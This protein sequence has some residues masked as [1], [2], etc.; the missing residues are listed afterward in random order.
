MAASLKTVFQSTEGGLKGIG[1][2]IE[3]L[4]KKQ[5]L[6]TNSIQTFGRMGKNVDGLRV[7]Y[8]QVTTQVNRL[9]AAQTRLNAAQAKYNTLSSAAGKLKGA[10]A[11]LAMA[12]TVLAAPLVMGVSEAKKYQNEQAKVRA[13][14]LGTGVTSDAF[15]FAK[16]MKTYGTSQLDNLTLVRDALSVFGD[17]DDAKMAA[18]ILA[19]MKFGNAAVF[20]SEQGAENE[21]KF[22]DM[23]KVIELRNGT[24]SK[25]AFGAQANMVQK[26]I[27][28]TGGRVGPE[29]WR[30]LIATGGL[31]AKGMRDDAFYFQL[32]HLVQES[33]G[34]R[35]GTGLSAAY[36]SLYQGRTTKRALLNLEK[37]GLIGDKSKTTPDKA[38]QI[39]HINPG[40][41]LGSD[42]FRQSQFEWVKQVL[43]PTLAK[44]G[45]TSKDAITDAIG[46][47]VSNRK[48]GDLLATM[49]LQQRQIEKDER[50]S[51][52]SYGVDQLDK[53][54]RNNAGGKELDAEAK[55]NN[56][57]LQMGKDIMPL[58]IHAL[59]LG[60]SA[61]EK[62]NGFMERNPLLTK[63]MMV[64]LAGVASAALVLSPIL[65]TVGG[66][67]SAYAGYTLLMGK[68]AVAAAQGT[69]VMG[70]LARGIM[71]VGTTL[72]AVSMAML[73]SPI[74]WIVA[75]LGIAAYELYKHWDAVKSWF[76][77][78]WADMK[79]IFGGAVDFIT[80]LMTGNFTKAIDGLKESFGGLGSFVKHVFDG[81]SQG[82]ATVVNDAL[83]A[84]GII[85]QTR[86][87]NEVGK[88][89][90]EK[91]KQTRDATML[92]SAKALLRDGTMALPAVAGMWRSYFNQTASHDAAV[93]AIK[94]NTGAPGE[95][96]ELPPM[97]S[98]RGGRGNSQGSVDA[99]SSQP[100][101]ITNNWNITQQPGEDSEAFA[102]RVA[103]AHAEQMAKMQR[104]QLIDGVNN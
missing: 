65:V 43:I 101:Q 64:G 31:A 104:G 80:G 20:G 17:I 72:R 102:Q 76:S 52:G 15:R 25:E 98:S 9:Q 12:G 71:T 97:A 49:Y 42:L 36:S 99:D 28:A 35:V 16:Q 59:E 79:N 103:Q 40:A 29:E 70:I 1:G 84:M 95:D 50:L 60:T 91:E 14:G 37:Y 77:G 23:L 33:G 6:L 87:E 86:R 54:G 34:D 10:G 27:S 44:H 19:K 62:L 75:G 74:F 39:A 94:W 8:A 67:L 26:V 18:P 56:L 57:R 4:T 92:G 68:F 96:V 32:E 46:S 24:S 85:D 3:A 21:S 89:L 100:M 63:V 58:Y 47:I 2:Q 90:A 66:A 5:K 93:N 78:L 7:Q 13:L 88:E 81:I 22:M 45:I 41:L 11:T 48:G 73:T 82:L 51:R 61:L 38:G 83:T 53:E 69:G 30:H 55:L